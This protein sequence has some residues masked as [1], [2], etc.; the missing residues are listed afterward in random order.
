V[1]SFSLVLQGAVD[2]HVGM[3]TAVECF[4]G[5]QHNMWNSGA[6]IEGMLTEVLFSVLRELLIE[7]NCS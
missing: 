6:A 7:L 1:W 5:V 3:H 4:L 2:I